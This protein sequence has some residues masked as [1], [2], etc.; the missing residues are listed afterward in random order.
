MLKEKRKRDL[1]LQSHISK[2]DGKLERQCLLFCVVDLEDP[3]PSEPG[4]LG[5]FCCLS[6]E[7]SKRVTDG[8]KLLICVST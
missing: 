8:N 1:T 2:Q 6:C 4:S 3:L 5:L 7:K